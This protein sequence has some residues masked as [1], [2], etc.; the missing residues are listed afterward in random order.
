MVDKD[1]VRRLWPFGA[2][3]MNLDHRT[4]LPGRP[5]KAKHLIEDEFLRRAAAKQLATSLS[6]EAHELREWLVEHHPETPRPTVGTIKNNIR[7]TYNRL[8]AG[9]K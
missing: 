6:L 9:T 1:A 4:G 2:E 3:Q 5:G 8:K 7:A